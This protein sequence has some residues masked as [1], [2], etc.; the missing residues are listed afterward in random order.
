MK[1]SHKVPLIS[2]RKVAPSCKPDVAKKNKISR[3][4]IDYAK[5]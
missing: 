4:K 1:L 5:P 2:Y 3:K